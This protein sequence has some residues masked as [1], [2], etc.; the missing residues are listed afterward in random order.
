MALVTTLLLA[1][2]TLFG[3]SLAAHA[4]GGVTVYPEDGEFIKPLVFSNLID[5]AVA[6]ENFAFV[7]REKETDV[8]KVFDGKSLTAYS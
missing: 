1:A 4:E 7:E 3:G 8:I 6:G 2:G 5:Y